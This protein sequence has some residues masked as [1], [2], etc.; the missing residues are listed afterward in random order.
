MK[1]SK[2]MVKVEIMRE[3][4]TMLP[5]LYFKYSG[6]IIILLTFHANFHIMRESKSES[7]KKMWRMKSLLNLY[8]Q[9]FKCIQIF[10]FYTN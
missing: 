4:E 7:T 6:W 10:R 1:Y 3:K 2:V 5:R 8:N 9:R